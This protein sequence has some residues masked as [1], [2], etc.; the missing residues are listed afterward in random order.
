MYADVVGVSGHAP[1][2]EIGEMANRD[3]W[4]LMLHCCYDRNR[5]GQ[6]WQL[7]SR[8][9]FVV[10]HVIFN[11]WGPSCDSVFSFRANKT[12]NLSLR[13]H[14][15][16]TS[17]SVGRSRFCFFYAP[18]SRLQWER[19]RSLPAHSIQRQAVQPGQAP[20]QD[21]GQACNHQRGPLCRW[22]SPGDTLKKHFRDWLTALRMPV[23]SSASLSASKRLRWWDKEPTPLRAST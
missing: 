16:I 13:F 23:L 10:F 18:D 3:P 15:T 14:Y 6:I 2:G 4:S 21:Q 17:S 8:D 19:R 1:F 22:R 7:F 20:S 9:A 5:R 11:M 12:H